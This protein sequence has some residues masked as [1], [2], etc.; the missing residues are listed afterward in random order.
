MTIQEINHLNRESF[1]AAIGPVF[2]SSS[3]IAD[4]TWPR[5]PFESREGLLAAL[6]AT[7]EEAGPDLLL[8]LIQ[9]HP[10]L[11]GRL[12][13]QG[14]LTRESGEEQRAAGIESLDGGSRASLQEL[15]ARYL[16]KFGFPFIICA[17]LNS[18]D[19]ILAAFQQR[20]ESTREQEIRLAWE[21]IKKIA[22][23]RLDAV[24]A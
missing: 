21:E 12:A 3:W 16:E 6:I 8:Q 13:E 14:L 2:E 1:L 4:E 5:R 22:A 9:A 19:S 20:M 23:L 24:V 17:R 10:D 15:N 7:V 18:P 11:G